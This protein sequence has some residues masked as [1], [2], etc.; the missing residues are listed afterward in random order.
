MSFC[1]NKDGVFY[2]S[3][4]H[5]WFELTYAEF[6]TVPRLVLESMSFEWQEK[7][8]N[9]LDEIDETFDWR[10]EEG[11]YWVKLRDANGCF[12]HAPLNNYR[13]GSV[14]HLRKNIS[15]S[16]MTPGCADTGD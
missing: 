5:V 2:E 9:L 4:I 16:P 1:Q 10:P 14:E 13:H 8:A 15:L 3:P 7:M 12:S 11:R 6:L